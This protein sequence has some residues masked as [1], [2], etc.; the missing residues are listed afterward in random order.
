MRTAI[1]LLAASLSLLTQRRGPAYDVVVYGGTAGGVITAV[2]AAREGLK[3]AL[4]SP[5]HHLGGMV[6]GGLGW[7][8]YGRKEVI[9]GYSREFFERVGRKYGRDIEWHFEP[10][11][12]E[13]VFND[14]VKEAGVAVFLDQRLREKSGVRKTGTQLA[15]IVME[16][17]AAYRASIFA[18]ATYEGDLM[19]QAGVS[20]TWGREAI[21]E[22]GESL[23]GVREHMPLHQFRAAVSPYDGKGKLLPEIMPRSLDGVGAADTRVQAY[24]FRLCMTKTPEN[25][26]DWPKPSGYS[27]ARYELVARYLPA[28]ETE[29]KRPLGINDVMKADILQNGKTDTNNNG[30]FSTDYIGGSYGY[31]QASYA[32]RAQIRQSHVDY[33]KGFMYFLATDSRVP[34][35]LSAEMKQWGLCRDEF[36]DNDH[37][38]YQLYVREARRMVGEFVMS[39]KDIQTELTK[40]DVIGM[41]SYNSD[42]HNVQRR[43]SEDG[44]AVENEGDMQ[45]PVTPYQIPFRLVLPKRAQTTNLL[46]PVAF[47]ATHVAYSTLR[48]EPQYMIVGQ[49][50]GVAAKM[51]IER[52][53]A[54]QDF[55]TVALCGKLKSQRAVFSID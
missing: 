14:L 18:D 4:V 17:G 24:N 28:F 41:G 6:S 1:L 32:K 21:S 47:S 38:P 11:V 30:A 9:G 55:D 8:D 36:A 20:Y 16:S 39:Q 51:A 5:D 46:V 15:E 22:Y 45:V 12:A 34:A 40:P 29:L 19:A 48:M 42:S 37:W 13:A 49:A 3:V 27:P 33:I 23:A 50:T 31:P 25:R 10:H 52:K 35:A 54:V 44:K 26:V 53:Q 7:T 2:A 43:P